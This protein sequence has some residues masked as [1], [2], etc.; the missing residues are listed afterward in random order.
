M[1]VANQENHLV[2]DVFEKTTNAFSAPLIVVA[3]ELSAVLQTQSNQRTMFLVLLLQAKILDNPL[4]LLC[5]KT[6]LVRI[7]IKTTTDAYPLGRS[8]RQDRGAHRHQPQR[9]QPL[10]LAQK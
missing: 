5:L 2:S 8:I 4:W 9:H 1:A 6:D 7:G 3:E 10:T